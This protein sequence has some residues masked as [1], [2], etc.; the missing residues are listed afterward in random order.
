MFS[1]VLLPY[2]SGTPLF[3]E[4][5]VDYGY[6]K[7]QLIEHLRAANFKFYILNHAF[8]MDLPHP[9]YVV[10]LHSERSMLE[11]LLLC[12]VLIGSSREN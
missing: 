12:Y 2:S 9:E 4:R 3:D 11:G 7:V 10:A 5:F 6:N 1:Y 8:A